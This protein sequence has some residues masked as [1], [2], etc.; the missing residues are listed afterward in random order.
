MRDLGV[1]N[2]SVYTAVVMRCMYQGQICFMTDLGVSNNPV[3]TNVVMR[4]MY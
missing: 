2:Y 1:S 3:Y 4:C